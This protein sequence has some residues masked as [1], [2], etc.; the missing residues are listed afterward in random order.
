MKLPSGLGLAG[1][2]LCCTWAALGQH[3]GDPGDYDPFQDAHAQAGRLTLGVSW[4]GGPGASDPPS[5][6]PPS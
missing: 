1:A 5:L 3:R 4:G 2:A 6:R